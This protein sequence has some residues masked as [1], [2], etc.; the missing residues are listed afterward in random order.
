ME[1]EASYSTGAVTRDEVEH[2]A[3]SDQELPRRAGLALKTLLDDL[4]K[5]QAAAASTAINTGFARVELG[6]LPPNLFMRFLLHTKQFFP[7]FLA[8]N[9]ITT[10]TEE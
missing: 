4:A 2:L 5:A 3:A 8:H 7:L 10:P 1:V 9:I 6:T